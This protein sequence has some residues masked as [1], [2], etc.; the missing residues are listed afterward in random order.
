MFMQWLLEDEDLEDE[1]AILQKLLIK[2][3]NNGCL[4]SVN[5]VKDVLLH[6]LNKHPKIY[7]EIRDTFASALRAYDK[8]MKQ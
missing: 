6:F 2:D 5:N 7:A 8:E 1:V 4:T 3:Y